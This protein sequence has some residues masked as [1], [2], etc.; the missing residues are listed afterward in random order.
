MINNVITYFGDYSYEILR[1]FLGTLLDSGYKGN[2]YIFTHHF[3]YLKEFIQEFPFKKIFIINQP[4]PKKIYSIY[5]W[6]FVSVFK[7]FESNNKIKEKEK[8]SLICD[9]RDLLFQSNPQKINLQNKNVIIAKENKKIYKCERWNK[10][11]ADNINYLTKDVDYYKKD[12]LCC[13]CIIVKNSYFNN[14]ANLF[15]EY[16]CKYNFELKIMDQGIINYL[17]Y[18]NKFENVELLFHNNNIMVHVG[19]NKE[20]FIVDH[21][22][23]KI[24]NSNKIPS[25]IHHYDRLSI[26]ELDKISN[27]YNFKIKR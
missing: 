6:K 17:V 18:K 5:I 16:V 26:N 21:D 12:I 14:F 1:R 15:N 19:N 8:F 11:W 4:Y 23:I 10:K 20:N 24:K 22:K 25:I 2:I 27:K 13:G 7:Y 9:V 3:K